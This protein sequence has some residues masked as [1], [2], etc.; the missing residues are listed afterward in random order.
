M[1]A[2]FSL[3]GDDSDPAGHV[4]NHFRISQHT[5][6]ENVAKMAGVTGPYFGQNY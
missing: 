2:V 1:A 5:W 6:Y 3:M 4:A